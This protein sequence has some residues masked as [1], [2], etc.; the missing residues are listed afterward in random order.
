MTA[1]IMQ[2]YFLPYIGYFQMMKCADVF[3]VYDNIQFSKGG[4]INRNRILSN[5]K[6]VFITL[7]LKKDSDYLDIRER[8]LS[9]TFQTE[10][11]SIL[12][13]IEGSYKKAP[14]F[15]NVFPIAEEILR[16]NDANLF[17][18]LINSIKTI[19]DYLMIDTKI[20]ISS[21]LDMDHSLKSEERV[22]ETC[23]TLDADNYINPIGGL[24]L[25][26]K[27]RFNDAGIN[28]TFLKTS[29]FIYNQFENIFIP[30]L[31]ILDVMMF[32]DCDRIHEMLN[33]YS[34]L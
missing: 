1:V 21:S 27:D 29:D 2:P 26:S 18:F 24:E 13:R 22:I 30:Y 6:D 32:N 33:K 7:P 12:R 15:K 28:L 23:K 31:S 20:I 3:V 34:L 4:W 19:N 25:Y 10:R 5:G 9:D 14:H 11:E 16:Y 17:K 8:S